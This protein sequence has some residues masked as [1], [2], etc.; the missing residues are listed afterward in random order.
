MTTPQATT[1]ETSVLDVATKT[2]ASRRAFLKNGTLAALA[3]GALGAC[4]GAAN[5]Q[6]LPSSG[7]SHGADHSGG[8]TA[9]HPAPAAAPLGAPLSLA[10]RRA[11]ADRMDAMHERGIK[12]FPAPTAG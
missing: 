2:I 9:A 4:K 7:A 6:T 8:T 1:P 12:A 10:Q 11:N 5:A 3:A